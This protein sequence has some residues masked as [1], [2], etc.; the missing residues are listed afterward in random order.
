MDKIIDLFNRTFKDVVLLLYHDND[1]AT[2]SMMKD[3]GKEYNIMVFEKKEF[4]ILIVVTLFIGMFAACAI[5]CIISC[6]FC[7]LYPKQ[8]N[9]NNLSSYYSSDSFSKQQDR[10]YN[11]FG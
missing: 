8:E 10:P 4:I 11:Y 7:M 2:T 5:G 6:C 9:E 3:I 1:H